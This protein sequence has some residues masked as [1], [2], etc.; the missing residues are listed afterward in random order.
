[1]I[2]EAIAKAKNAMSNTNSLFEFNA[3]D[4]LY[5][6]VKK[7][8][9]DFLLYLLYK[10]GSQADYDSLITDEDKEAYKTWEPNG[11]QIKKKSSVAPLVI[12]AGI[13]GAFMLIVG[14]SGE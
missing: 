9:K 11:I 12:G 4:K 7:Y 2:D 6:L 3:Y 1:M 14:G 13:I 8:G 10:Y 5:N